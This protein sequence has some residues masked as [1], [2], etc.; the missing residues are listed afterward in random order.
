[1]YA[2]YIKRILDFIISLAAL[3]ILS[4]VLLVLM[5]I[6]AAAMKGNPFFTQQRPGKNE[7]IFNLIKFRTFVA[8]T[9]PGK[10]KTESRR[11]PGFSTQKSCSWFKN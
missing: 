1:M 11:F 7:K 2:K 3:I 6:T 9:V 4:P 5:I 10:S 8:P